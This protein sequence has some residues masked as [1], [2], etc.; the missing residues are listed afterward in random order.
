[1]AGGCESINRVMRAASKLSKPMNLSLGQPDS[2]VPEL[3]KEAAR[4]AIAAGRNSYAPPQGLPE[5][6]ARLH[7]DLTA[8]IGRDVG[9]ILITSGVTGGLLLTLMA[10]T[11]A[12]DEVIVLDPYFVLY[13]SLLDIIGVRVVS[14]DTYP[15]FRFDAAR[16]QAAVSPRTKVLI[17]NSPNNPTG[18]V[19]TEAEVRAAAE[20][21]RLNNLL[22]ISDE[23]YAAFVYD[24]AK[25]FPTP[26]RHYDGTVL[27]RGF[28]KSHAMTGWRI[29]Y[30]SGPEAIIAR[31]TSL[32]LY[33]YG[34]APTPFQHAALAA[35]DVPSVDLIGRYR[36]NR[37]LVVH[38]LKG[39]VEFALPQGGFY[40]FPPVP[41][42]MSGTA[43]VDQAMRHDLVLFPGT[44][45]SERDTHFRLSYCVAEG[46][47][48]RACDML[49]RLLETAPKWG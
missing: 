14:V 27:L 9:D 36:R 49:V 31:M 44:A 24:D 34:C 43:F 37:D 10:S 41:K 20:V 12:G 38:Q 5:L 4:D 17:V 16:V 18:V 35:L 2:D 25:R 30:A 33:L 6:R 48:E 32:A 22:L 42:N 29:G 40:A 13:R 21:A 46:V 23:I 3:V 47:L 7:H 39:H 45:F 8:E 26:M 28:S 19:L 11:N 15:N 1:M